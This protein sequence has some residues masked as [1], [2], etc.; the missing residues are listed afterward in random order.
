[1]FTRFDGTKRTPRPVQTQALDWLRDGWLTDDIH[2]I[3]GP[4]GCGKSGIGRAVQIET[5]AAI[6]TPSNILIDQY[7]GSYPKVNFLKGK[8]HYRCRWGVSCKDWVDVMEQTPCDRCTYAECR[9]K[10]TEGRPTFYN[11]MSYY[12][13]RLQSGFTPNTVVVDEAHQVSSMVLA[14]CSKKFRQSVYKFTDR[15][16]NELY[17]LTW[18]EEQRTKLR[19]LCAQYQKVGEYA[20][21]SEI[22]DEIESVTLV[23]KGMTEDPHNYAIWISRGMH[24]GK[25]ENFLNVKPVRPP[26][27]MVNGMLACDKLVLMSGT[28]MKTDIEDLVGGRPYR[29]IDLPSPIPRERRQVRYRPM[30]FPVNFKT[31]PKQIVAAIEAVL[32]E[33]VGE[34]TMIHVTYSMALKLRPHFRRPVLVNTPENKIEQVEFFKKHGGVFLAAGCAEGLDLKDDFCRVNII[35]KLA[36]PD[37]N[38]PVV[39]KR[40]AMEDGA[41]WYGLE[42]LKVAIQ[43]AGR[44]TRHETDHSTTYI[45]DPTFGSLFNRYRTKLP[46]SFTEAIVWS[47]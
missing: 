37:L 34:N 15:C 36:Y 33:H 17:L 38:D 13:L 41:E 9:S 28:L 40:K 6:I 46:Q 32:D 35:P 24:R 3:Q 47:C 7:I 1:M 27:F 2:A 22:G 23:I 8:A 44:S 29:F 12:Y 31:D 11:P 45:M 25:P 14:L 20:K 43:A 30:Q 19:K 39:S 18:L 42:A 5:R 10:A 26:K 4:V 16:M 21:A